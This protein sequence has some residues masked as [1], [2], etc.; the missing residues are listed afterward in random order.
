MSTESVGQHGFRAAG[1]RTYPSPHQVQETRSAAVTELS[2]RTGCASCS[3]KPSRHCDGR[4][5][6]SPQIALTVRCKGGER[7]E[8]L[9]IEEISSYG[10]QRRSF[11]IV[12][13][14]PS[15]RCLGSCAGQFH[16]RLPDSPRPSARWHPRQGPPTPPYGPTKRQRAVWLVTG[17]PNSMAG[18]HFPRDCGRTCTAFDCRPG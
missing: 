9:R 18:P 4:E 17:L 8:E 14:P 13:V 16:M 6:N 11:W 7:I 10:P 1:C 5:M 12:K 2:A 3:D 15:A